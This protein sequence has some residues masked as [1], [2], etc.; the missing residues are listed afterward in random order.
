M[1]PERAPLTDASAFER[2]YAEQYWPLLR[3]LRRVSRGDPRCEDWVQEA[4]TKAW[5]ARDRFDGRL[6]RTWLYTIAKNAMNDERRRGIKRVNGEAFLRFVS[7]APW[8]IESGAD[9]RPV[10]LALRA[11][12]PEPAFEREETRAEVRALL[13]SLPAGNALLFWQ[14]VGERLNQTACGERLGLTLGSV[15]SRLLRTRRKLRRQHVES[16]GIR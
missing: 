3:W 6:P 1:T 13:R 9:P 14:C 2:F 5:A 4:F 11:E 8:E 12:S 10:P 16:Y 15:K 7:T